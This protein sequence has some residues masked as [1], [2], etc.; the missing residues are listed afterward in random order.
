MNLYAQLLHCTS[1]LLALGVFRCGAQ[2]FDAIG[3][4]ADIDRPPASIASE[5]H[6]PKLAIGTQICCDAQR[7]IFYNDVVGSILGT[8]RST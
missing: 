2:N 4:T 8:K 3:G 7:G 6:D 5:A 1:Q